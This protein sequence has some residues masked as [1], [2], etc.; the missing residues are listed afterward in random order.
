MIFDYVIII[1]VYLKVQAP[2]NVAQC[3]RPDILYLE[4]IKHTKENSEG[5]LVYSV[6]KFAKRTCNAVCH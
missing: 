1:Y 3:K 6:A 4:F 2:K 5:G